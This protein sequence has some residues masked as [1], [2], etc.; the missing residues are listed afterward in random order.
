MKA[1]TASQ[2]NVAEAEGHSSHSPKHNK[3]AS[4]RCLFLILSG[5]QSMHIQA[6]TSHQSFVCLHWHSHKAQSAHQCWC[7]T[8]QSAQWFANGKGDNLIHG[9]F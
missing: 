2:Q 9:H 1:L 5:S 3:V 4:Q 6:N 8:G 7:L